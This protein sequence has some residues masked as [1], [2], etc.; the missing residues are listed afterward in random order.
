MYTRFPAALG[1]RSTNAQYPHESR[2]ARVSGTNTLGEY[3]TTFAF[4][5]RGDDDDASRARRRTSSSK[6]SA[7]FVTKA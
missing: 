4:V 3:V 5:V 2:H 6:S 7:D 1:S